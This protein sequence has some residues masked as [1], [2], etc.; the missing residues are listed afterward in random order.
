MSEELELLR[1]AARELD[2][3]LPVVERLDF[4]DVSML[5]WGLGVPRLVFLHGGGQNAHTWDSVLLILGRAALAVDLPGHGHSARR[6]DHDYWP[7]QNARTLAPVV[8]G[9]DSVLLVGMSLGG[10]TAI[11]LAAR[12][13]D[14]IAGLVVVD[15]T[16]DVS[17]R[18]PTLTPTQRGSTALV[19]GV[20]S[21]ATREE[22]VEL[23]VRA[24]PRR[25]AAAVRRGVLH[26]TRRRDDG[27]WEWR[28]D[29]GG[30][31]APD[32]TPL[33]DDVGRLRMPTLLVRGGESAFVSD[34]DE[35][36][37]VRTAPNARA[38]TMAGAGHAVQSDKPRE[39][40]QIVDEFFRSSAQSHV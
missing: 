3:P 10:L 18:M 13:P 20:G 26:N 28:Y 17:L 7:W 24:S 25:P 31:P 37:F 30:H 2:A 23:A 19:D 38:I 8:I 22:M 14:R 15:V 4:S 16:P 29:L 12:R 33:W 39:L 11:R 36:T 6:A 35:E 21:F 9:H 27:R 1:E 5:R 34:D 40:A 32:F